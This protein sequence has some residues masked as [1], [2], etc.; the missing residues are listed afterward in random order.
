LT[1]L[2]C[3]LL[4]SIEDASWVNNADQNNQFLLFED[5]I[6]QSRCQHTLTF[7][8]LKSPLPPGEVQLINAQRILFSDF[9]NLPKKDQE[10]IFRTVMSMLRGMKHFSRASQNSS[11]R[12]T[13]LKELNYYCFFVAGIIGEGLSYLFQQVEPLFPVDSESLKR[14]VHFGLF[15]QKV[16]IL[17]DQKKDEEEGRYLVPDQQ[18]V[19]KSLEGHAKSGLEYLLQIPIQQTGYRIFCAWSLF[20]GLF[21]LPKIRNAQ[22]QNISLKIP[23]TQTW[24]F[25]RKIEK[26]IHDN[27]SLTR[28]YRELNLKVDWSIEDHSPPNPFR[29]VADRPTITHPEH[30]PD[31]FLSSYMGNI[32]INPDFWKPT[33]QIHEP[34]SFES[35]H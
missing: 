18:Q 8:P 12:L 21:T 15:L 35:I 30:V 17:K 2:I 24:S 23:R 11:L 32:S 9:H 13:D 25:L 7:Q 22:R 28:L 3:R 29:P 34:P 6:S 14:S 1:Y 27:D 5:L 4:D 10:I 33:S 26:A 20:L 19:Y 16:N 31:W